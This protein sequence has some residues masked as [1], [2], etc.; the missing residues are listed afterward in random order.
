VAKPGETT[1]LVTG[2]SGYLGGWCLVELLRRGYRVRATVRSLAKESEL[3]A[4]L[5]GEVEAEDRLSVFRADLTADSGWDEAAMGCDYVLHVASPNPKGP[6][7]RPDDLIVPARE[8]TLRVL[9]A[10]L[11]AGVS[12]VVVTSS[13]TAIRHPREKPMRPYDESDWT[14]AA[15]AVPYARAKTIAERAAWDLVSGQ[16]A[17]DRLATVLPGAVIGPVLNG[18]LSNSMQIITRPLQRKP[19]ALPRLGFALVDVR[20]IADLHIKAMTTPEA[21]G[22]RFIGVAEFRWL[23]DIARVLREGLRDA[24]ARVPTRP[25]PDI[26]FRAFATFVP[27][28]REVVRELNQRYDYSTQQARTLLGWSPRPVEDTIL[29]SAHSLIRH[30]VVKAPPSAR[31]Q[32]E[33]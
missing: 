10:G 13:S 22:R 9:R 23:S 30:G 25:M 11:R 31:D 4:A 12:R 24:G 5:A 19:P 2:G 3:R 32:V 1:V 18:N 29:D 15:R 28:L 7:K 27:Q 20:D 8:G 16:G 6:P 14:D 26:A 17:S 33:S 21:A